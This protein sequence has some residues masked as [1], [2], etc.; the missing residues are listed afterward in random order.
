MKKQKWGVMTMVA[1]LCL[2]GCGNSI[3]LNE[4]QNAEAAEYIAGVLLK[5]SSNYD[6]SLVYPED[7]VKVENSAKPEETPEV[8][9]EENN[10]GGAEGENTVD[11]DEVFSL[12]G[13]QFTC[14]GKQECREYTQKNAKA[15]AVYANDKN[16][17]LVIVD[18]KVKNTTASD[19]K[20]KLMKKGYRYQLVTS[21]GT[22]YNAQ[23]TA[24]NND[25]NFL[26]EKVEAGKAKKCIVIFEVPKKTNVDKCQLNILKGSSTA[27]L[28]IK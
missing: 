9:S 13:F 3:E 1:V 25:I 22:S 27:T 7:V 12:S 4:R 26:S 21:D 16:K 23:I 11:A 20:I 14:V 19:K 2:T 5:H 10:A 8:T 17:K 24:F 6:K 15:Y 28:E 18:I